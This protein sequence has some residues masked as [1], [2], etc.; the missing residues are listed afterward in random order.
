MKRTL[1]LLTLNIASPS[2]ERAERLLEWLSGRPDDILVLTET[3]PG[4][5]T[6]LTAQRLRH[7]G[8]ELRFPAPG[9]GERGVMVAARVALAPRGADVI[10]YLPARA[11]RVTL[12]LEQL[13]VIG[14]YVPS[15]DGTAVKTERKQAFVRALAP[16]LEGGK[17]RAAVLIGDFNIV[18][19]DHRPR[20]SEFA[21]WEYDFYRGLLAT[22]WHDAYRL[23]RPEG[24]E[25][26]WVGHHDDGY[27]FDHVFV[28]ETLADD[29][30]ACG[31]LHEPRELGL[32]DHSAMALQLSAV[33]VRELDVD[34]SLT[35]EHGAL[36]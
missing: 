14:V 7:A 11:E 35:A 21:A 19:P 15:R 31:Y 32:S 1:S 9:S 29:V 17:R 22:G 24:M 20:R 3:S 34:D 36:F 10:E 25:Y 13:D 28:T 33:G 2:V 6:A 26:S 8:W 23:I 16:A 18:E 30:E 27:R 12:A 4:P 5:G